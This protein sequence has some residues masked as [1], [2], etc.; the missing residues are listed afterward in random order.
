MSYATYAPRPVA[1]TAGLIPT[2]WARPHEEWGATQLQD[3]FR[4]AAKRWMTARDYAA[5][6]AVRAIGEAPA[7]AQSVEPEKLVA[8][9]RGEQF[10][11]GGY[12]GTPLR[13]RPWGGPMRQAILLPH[14]RAPGSLSP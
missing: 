9:M 3:R 10:Q 1:G 8:L 6:L 2:A 12:K 4:Q 14:T 11:L 5:W 13:F 7:R